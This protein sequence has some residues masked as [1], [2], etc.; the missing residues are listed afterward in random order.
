MNDSMFALENIFGNDGRHKVV[1][2]KWPWDSG[3]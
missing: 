2:T 1:M 3:G